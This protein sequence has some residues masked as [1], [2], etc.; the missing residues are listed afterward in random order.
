VLYRQVARWLSKRSKALPNMI[1]D[2]ADPDK[3]IVGQE[4]SSSG[5]VDD[6]DQKV[7]SKDEPMELLTKLLGNYN[8]GDVGVDNVNCF[9]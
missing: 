6:A 2:E 4:P 5:I 9:F 7:K 3:F 8:T 1:S